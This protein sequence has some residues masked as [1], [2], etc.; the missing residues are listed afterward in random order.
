MEIIEVNYQISSLLNDLISMIQPR[1]TDK[2]LELKIDI[3][4]QIPSELYGD[5]VRIRQI[6]TNLL[7]NAVKYTREGSVTLQQL[8]AA[9][10]AG[11]VA[12]IAVTSVGLIIAYAR[13]GIWDAHA[14]PSV[15][16]NLAYSALTALG[17]TVV[18]LGRRLNWPLALGGGAAA[19]ALC[20][21]LLCALMAYVRHR[22][23]L[24]EETL[25][26]EDGDGPPPQG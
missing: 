12:V 23:Q 15:R 2:G 25:D 24:E 14:R 1:A 9:Q 8:R 26:A 21:L 19:F 10:L 13:R 20:F 6:I 18:L 11:E 4:D 3:D 5:E 16:G 22:Q 17:V 7:T